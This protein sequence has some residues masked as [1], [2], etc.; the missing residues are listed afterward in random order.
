MKNM[1]K[2]MFY[3]MTH[4]THYFNGGYFRLA[5]KNI[6]F[7][8]PAHKPDS[9]STDFVTPVVALVGTRIYFN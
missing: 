1:K 5:A 2:E 3:L 9:T 4:S 7:Y 6:L 8:A